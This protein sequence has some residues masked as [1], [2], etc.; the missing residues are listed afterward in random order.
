MNLYGSTETAVPQ[1]ICPPGSSVMKRDCVGRPNPLAEILIVDDD[2]REVPPGEIGEIW[3][4]SGTVS[5]GYWRNPEATARE[6]IA[7][8]WKSGDLG[9]LDADGS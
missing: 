4:R 6:F 7:G 9:A 1:A 3:L 2:G 8:F 5:P